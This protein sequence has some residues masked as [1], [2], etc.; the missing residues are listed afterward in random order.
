MGTPSMSDPDSEL[1]PPPCRLM[2]TRERFSA[3]IESGVMMSVRT[4]AVV[5]SSIFTGYSLRA[6]AESLARQ[7]SVWTRRSA[8]LSGPEV[9][10]GSDPSQTCASGLTVGGMGTTRVM[11]AVPS[12]SKV[13]ESCEGF[14]VDCADKLEARDKT[15]AKQTRLVVFIANSRTRL[16]ESCHPEA[17][18]WRGGPMQLVENIG[19]AGKVH[20]SSG[21]QTR[22]PSG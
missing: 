5:V 1:N 6:S 22:G 4:P 14:E 15:N 19:A 10:F 9:F 17:R 2:S 7:A 16:A 20:R 8:R 11:C 3:G 12:G 21:P 18:S 13:A